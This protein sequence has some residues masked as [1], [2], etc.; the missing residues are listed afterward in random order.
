LALEGNVT[1]TQSYALISPLSSQNRKS[2]A[3]INQN[4]MLALKRRGLGRRL[5]GTTL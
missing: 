3:D 2:E 4:T 1:D 5:S